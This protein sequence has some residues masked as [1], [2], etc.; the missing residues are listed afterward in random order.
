MNTTDR[1]ALADA[2]TRL[3]ELVEADELEA[4]PEH[5]A[6]MRGYLAG[7]LTP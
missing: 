1:R 5:V 2:V 3:L 4:T 6:W 7:L